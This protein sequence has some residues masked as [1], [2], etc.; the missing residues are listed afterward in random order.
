VLDKLC[1]RPP[2][3]TPPGTGAIELQAALVDAETNTLDLAPA[4]ADAETM[5]HGPPFPTPPRRGAQASC[6]AARAHARAVLR[7]TFDAWMAPARADVSTQTPGS[8]RADVSTQTPGSALTLG[9]TQFCLHFL[10]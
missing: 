7:I 2:A 6:L 4:F 10:L 1:G 8:A 3:P 5:T 9:S